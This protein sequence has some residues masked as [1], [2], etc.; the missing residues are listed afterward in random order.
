MEFRATQKPGSA[1][2]TTEFE[3]PGDAQFSP[4][5]IEFFG[6]TV[7]ET[8]RRSGGGETAALDLPLFCDVRSA[9]EIEALVEQ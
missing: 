5:R 4:A 8:Y 7:A 3:M 2:P 1:P 6:Q 9:K